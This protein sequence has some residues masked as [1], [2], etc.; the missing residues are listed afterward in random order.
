M[1]GDSPRQRVSFRSVWHWL[2]NGPWRTEG[3]FAYYGRAFLKP[4]WFFAGVL[5]GVA[6]DSDWREEIIKPLVSE[7]T[8]TSWGWLLTLDFS[9]TTWGIVLLVAVLL[10]ATESG[11]RLYAKERSEKSDALRKVDDYETPKLTLSWSPVDGPYRWWDETRQPPSLYFGLCIKNDSNLP[12]T[13]VRV[14]LQDINPA[15]P[16]SYVPCPL[17]LRHN[18]LP[19]NKAVHEFSLNGGDK[20]FVQLMLQAE[21]MDSF[22]I[23]TAVESMQDWVVPIEEYTFSVRVSSATPGADAEGRYQIYRDGRLWNMKELPS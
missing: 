16:S 20:K 8:F 17:R 15:P 10:G 13:G 19:A 5:I 4:I 23:L 7:S 1:A 18:I 6:K 22:W 21:D 11:Y 2:W 14:E 12:V 3:R 9:W